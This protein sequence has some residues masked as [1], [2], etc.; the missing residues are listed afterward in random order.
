[1]L[2]SH[3]FEVLFH[4]KLHLDL[5]FLTLLGTSKGLVWGSLLMALNTLFCHQHLVIKCIK[6][7]KKQHF[8]F[9][10][11]L[12][13]HVF[14]ELCLQGHNSQRGAK[15]SLLEAIHMAKRGSAHKG[16][17]LSAMVVPPSPT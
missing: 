17:L 7:S 5:C 4:I 12:V 8:M 15:R 9:R 16:A 10:F 6:S 13:P 11:Y 3:L 14:G 1:M 2:A